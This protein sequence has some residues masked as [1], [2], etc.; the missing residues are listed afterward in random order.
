MLFRPFFDFTF[1]EDLIKKT[2][3]KTIHTDYARISTLLVLGQSFS[4]AN[5]LDKMESAFN[6][7]RRD[8]YDLSPVTISNFYRS[9]GEVYLELTNKEKA[10]EWFKSGLTINPK[11]GVKKLID[12]LENK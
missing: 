3:E 12:K 11:L 7:I 8:Q 5:D 6:I 4:K 1:E 9:V 10:L 2:L